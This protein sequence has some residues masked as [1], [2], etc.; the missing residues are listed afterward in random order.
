M[1]STKWNKSLEA[2]KFSKRS[3]EVT[4][5]R[6]DDLV[7]NLIVLVSCTIPPDQCRLLARRTRNEYIVLILPF[8]VNGGLVNSSLPFRA[9][10]YIQGSTYWLV[11]SHL[12]M[13]RWLIGWIFPLVGRFTL[14]SK[15]I[16]NKVTKQSDVYHTRSSPGLVHCCSR[17]LP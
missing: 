4:L 17:F 7:F 2:K 5:S 1:S 13:C 11:M 14:F 6:F 15:I 16:I 12:Y 10:I 3:F 8:F 9:I